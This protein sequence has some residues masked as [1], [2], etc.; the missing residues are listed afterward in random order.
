MIIPQSLSLVRGEV[1][2]P[3]GQL[4]LLT[5]V[6]PIAL[7]LLTQIAQMD[8]LKTKSLGP[9]RLICCWKKTSSLSIPYIILTHS[10]I[11][12]Q[13]RMMQHLKAGG[14]GERKMM[15]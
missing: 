12:R 10:R 1:C 8:R 7:V 14:C 2:W 4:I 11:T 3:S 6:L 9:S 5:L 13:L 15:G